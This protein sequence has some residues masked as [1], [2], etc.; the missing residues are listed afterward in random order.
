MTNEEKQA[1]AQDVLTL[2]KGESLSVDE[3]EEVTSLE[4]LQS[5]PAMSGTTLVAAPLTLLSKPAE[6]A[7]AT[8]NAATTAANTATENANNAATAARTAKDEAEKATENANTAATSATT[9]A[10]A[11]RTAATYAETTADTAA[12]KAEAAVNTTVESLTKRM[13]ELMALLIPTGL[14]V[15]AVGRMTLGNLAE[16]HIEARLTPAEVKQNL[17][18][19]SDGKAVTVAQDGRLTAVAVGRSVVQIVPTLNTALARAIVVEVGEP[20]LRTVTS[21]ALRLTEGGGLLMN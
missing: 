21:T 6:E 12:T 19:L 20:T 4:G 16:R 7:A 9:A 11:A 5:L 13:E 18:Y 3:L 1:V 14:E 8:A 17:L 2:M 10:T 15:E